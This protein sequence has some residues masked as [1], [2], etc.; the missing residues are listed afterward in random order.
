MT[1]RVGL[2]SEVERE[3]AR[4]PR[5]EEVAVRTVILK[6]EAL[7]S[8]L[9]YP[10]Q[11]AVRGGAEDLRELRPRSVEVPGAPSTDESARRSSSLDR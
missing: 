7:G 1:A 4:L 8:R 9:P 2:L 10:H 5:P 6:L 11:S 3:L